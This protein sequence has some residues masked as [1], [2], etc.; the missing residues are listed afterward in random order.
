MPTAISFENVSKLYQLGTFGTGTL[1]ND[2]KRWWVTSVL[3]KEDPF[4]KVGQVNNR[5][6]KAKSD[7][8]YALKDITFNVE[9]GDV[10]GVIGSNGAGKSTLLKLL[11]RITA[12]TTG[13]IKTKGRLATLLEVGTGFHGEL[14]GREN[15]Y[16]NGSIM[17]MTKQEIDKRLDEIIDFS[18]CEMYIDT[19]VK[20]Y[21][22]G[23]TIR[24]GFAVAAFLEPEILVVDEV[25]AVG[26]IEFQ[27]KAI[28][29]MSDIS[30]ENGRTVLFVS[31]N[32][33]SVRRLCKHGIV[34]SNGMID[35]TGD[36]DEA[37]NYYTQENIDTSARHLRLAD[38]NWGR[39]EKCRLG[40]EISEVT[41]LNDPDNMAT[42]EPIE[43]V[44]HIK[45]NRTDIRDGFFAIIIRDA[46]VGTRLLNTYTETVHLPE[47]RNEFDLHIT[48]RDHRLLDNKYSIQLEASSLVDGRTVIHDMVFDVLRFYVRFKSI[49]TREPYLTDWS[50]KGYIQFKGE[51]FVS[52]ETD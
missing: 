8:V 51:P 17:G 45:H 23:M 38:R 4:L 21:S 35:F 5:A 12:P 13:I 26:D 24:L 47:G 42:D 34:L 27:R 9:Q 50:D 39:N 33:G 16:I 18:G 49:K 46:T 30:H 19:P 10:V 20:R 3:G 1:S 32:M 22:S 25:L 29:K 40:L 15:I 36:I 2:I 11:S 41:M 14:T 37:V 6:A 44:L 48:I 31:H 52:V 28:G 43:L 7:F